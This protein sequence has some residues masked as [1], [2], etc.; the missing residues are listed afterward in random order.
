MGQSLHAKYKKGK[1]IVWMS[2]VSTTKS[3]EMLESEL[4][5]GSTG[6]RT[7][8]S[9]QSFALVNL[10]DFSAI[11]QEEI[12]L[13]PGSVLVRLYAEQNHSIINSI[14]ISRLLTMSL[15][16]VGV[17][18]RSCC[19]KSTLR[20]CLQIFFALPSASHGHGVGWI[21]LIPTWRK[22]PSAS[23]SSALE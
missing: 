12:L 4:F 20:H 23:T 9:I 21:S 14:P 15:T 2:F 1:K 6:D 13:L 7:I 8:F 22:L 10:R 18:T 17:F 5:L 3:A 16:A 11:K 19:D